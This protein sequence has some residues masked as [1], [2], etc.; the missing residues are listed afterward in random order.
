MMGLGKFQRLLFDVQLLWTY[1][2]NK[3]AIFSQKNRILQWKILNFG[4]GFKHFC[5]K[6][7]KPTP[8]SQIWSN[9]S[10]GVR[11]W[12]YTAARKKSTRESRLEN[13]GRL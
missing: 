8:L 12:H 10:F 2:Y 6:L 1:D 9:K 7:P 5:T 3:W 11:V 4:W 13:R